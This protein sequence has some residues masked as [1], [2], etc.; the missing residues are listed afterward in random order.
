M[1]SKHIK[2][3]LAHM[4]TTINF[5]ILAV[6]SFFLLIPVLLQAQ[7]QTQTDKK[8]AELKKLETG[9][10]NAKAKVALNERK[11]AVAD[12]L[13]NAGNQLTAESKTEA[14]AISTDRKK[15]D[16][17]YAVKEKP[18]SKLIN[19]KDKAEATKARADLKALDAQYKLDSKALD[20]RLKDA[21]KKSTTGN[22]NLT[23][24]KAGKKTAQDALKLS[25]TALDTAQEK[26]DVATGSGEE[27]SGKGKKKK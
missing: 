22:A 11:L 23:K 2:L 17:D 27:P 12:S 7:T 19:S 10:A 9:L 5:R 24:G 1:I 3:N 15:L 13:I 16:K 14:K 26:Y 8:A 18:V 6:L 4:K 20:T 25:Q 21:T